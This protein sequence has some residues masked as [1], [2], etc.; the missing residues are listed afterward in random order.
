MFGNQDLVDRVGQPFQ[1]AGQRRFRAPRSSLAAGT[2]GALESARTRQPGKAALR[3][4]DFDYNL[5]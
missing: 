5:E 1:A 3:V 2:H 4:A